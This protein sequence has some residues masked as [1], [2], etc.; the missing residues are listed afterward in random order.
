MPTIGINQVPPNIPRPTIWGDLGYAGGHV[1]NQILMAYLTG[2]MSTGNGAL[3]PKN[4]PNPQYGQTGSPGASFQLDNS[5]PYA[6]SP[7]VQAQY[8]QLSQQ[9]IAGIPQQQPGFMPTKPMLNSGQFDQLRKLQE[10]QQAQAQAPMDIQA[11]QNELKKQQ[12][13]LDPNSPL[14]QFLTAQAKNMLTRAQPGDLQSSGLYQ[15]GDIIERGG[16]R[17]KIVGVDTD[18][19]PLVEPE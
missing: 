12:Q 19:M 14:N 10:F 11:K 2:G 17:W 1:A 8:N 5:N 13:S 18:G 9:Q 7:L 4:I 15:S 6:N 3:A 16:K